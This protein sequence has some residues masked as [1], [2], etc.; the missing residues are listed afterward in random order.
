MDWPAHSLQKDVPSFGEAGYPSV[1]VQSWSGIFAPA[2]TPE[3]TLA[4]LEKSVG[5]ALKTQA[6]AEGFAKFGMNV[7]SVPRHR[8]ATIVREDLHRW[9]AV[10]SASG[11]KVDE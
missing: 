7:A 6:I 3:A 9:A 2:S 11:F 5:D 10:V 4:V 8:F 1:V